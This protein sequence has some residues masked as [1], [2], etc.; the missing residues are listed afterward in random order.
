[1]AKLNKGQEVSLTVLLRICSFL[2]ATLVIFVTR[3]RIRKWGLLYDR[4]NMS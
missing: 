2:I 3:L 4:E 1:M